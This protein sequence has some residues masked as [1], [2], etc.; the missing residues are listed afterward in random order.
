MYAV[1]ET[2]GRQVRVKVGD[3]VRVDRRAGEVGSEI[4]FDR[5]LLIGGDKA[6][7]VGQPTVE[8]ATVRGSIVGQGRDKKVLVY[9]YKPRQNSNRKRRGHRQDYTAVKIEA[10]DAR[11]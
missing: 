6:S 11:E 2:G 7:R 8:E 9:N 3:V 1:I 4:V 10:I 5:V